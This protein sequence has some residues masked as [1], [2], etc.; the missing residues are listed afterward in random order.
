MGIWRRG[1]AL[2]FLGIAANMAVRRASQRR[3]ADDGTHRGSI[4]TYQAAR[5]RVLIL[6]GGF[7]GLAAAQRLDALLEDRPDVSVLVVDHNSA[8][9]FTPLLWTVADGRV[10]PND[11]VVPIRAFQHGRSFHLLHAEVE[12]IDLDRRE[13][14]TSAGVRPFDYLVIALGSVTAVPSLPGL[15][16]RA[17]R[18]HTPADAMELRNHLID[19]VE[20][21]HQAVDVRERMEWLTFVV[22]GGGDTGIELAATIRDY[23]RAGLLAAYP[24]LAHETPRIVVVGRAERLV[25]MST[26]TTS[27]RVKDVLT[28][29]GIEVWTGAAIEGVT[30]R[31]VKTSRGEIPA[32]TLFWAAGISAPPVVRDLPV[33]HARNGA[34]NVDA[35]LRVPGHP[36]VFVVGDAAW[37]YDGVTGDPT[38]PTAQAAEHMGAYAGEAIASAIAGRSLPPFR[39]Q[40]RGRLALLGHRTGVA[41]VA[42]RAFSGIPAWLL[43]HGYY[44]SKIPSWRNRVRLLTDLLLA[45]LTGRETALLRLEPSR[46]AASDVPR[47][48]LRMTR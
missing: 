42:G 37:A 28:G 3:A 32:R 13:V 15:R 48:E 19:A 30:E 22:G 6:G 23:L 9:L 38:P 11:V 4:F 17:L 45:G 29:E 1:A 34:I 47:E 44:L 31:A 36:E 33:D 24:W 39:F 16:E 2:A 12:E 35:S 14:R 43:W 10:N 46:A 40:T 21:A 5:H 20:H 8:L 26:P 25:P 7:G 41:E 27:A 18:F